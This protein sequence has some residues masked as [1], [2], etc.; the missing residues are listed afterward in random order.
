MNL[1]YHRQSKPANTP[2][3][4]AAWLDEPLGIN[5]RMLADSLLLASGSRYRASLLERLDQ[6]FYRCSP[7]ID[8]S[9]LI[10]ELP[11][12]TAARLARE[13]ALATQHQMRLQD[14]LA[15]NLLI[16]ASDQVAALDNQALGKPGTVSAACQQLELMNGKTVVFSTALHVL[17]VDQGQHFTALDTTRATLRPLTRREIARYV[18][19]DQPLDCAGSFKVEALGISL[20]DAVQSDDPTAL[21]GLPLIA[22]C[23]GLRQFGWRIP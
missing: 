22:L 1:I 8:E 11:A 10:D 12:T 18:E 3:A 13:K 2:D 21:I 16:I 23:H 20:F 5:E 14:K 7:D 9:A 17:H 19:T 15:D 6:P 4:T